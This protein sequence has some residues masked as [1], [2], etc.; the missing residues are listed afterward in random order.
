MYNKLSQVKPVK[1]REVWGKRW[2]CKC[3]MLQKV[4]REINKCLHKCGR[5][6]LK[7]VPMETEIYRK[8]LMS[9]TVLLHSKYVAI[10][11]PHQFD[12]L[13]EF[14]EK[15]VWRIMGIIFKISIPFIVVNVPA[16]Y[17][18]RGWKYRFEF[19]ENEFGVKV[20]TASG[21]VFVVKGVGETVEFL[22]SVFA[23]LG[24]IEGG[25]L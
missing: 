6:E 7:L 22:V 23:M 11:S 15:C 19:F 3:V 4:I 5:R 24:Q 17:D 1:R 13:Q 12:N 14:L 9:V 8:H 2:C 20:F 16:V 25:E 21:D 10:K 18:E